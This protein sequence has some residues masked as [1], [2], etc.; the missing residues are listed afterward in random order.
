VEQVIGAAMC[1]RRAEYQQFG[2]MDEQFFMYFEEV[3]LCKRII[4][5]G[6]QVWFR[7]EAVV[8]HLGG[9]SA[10]ASDVRARMIVAFRDSRRQYFEKHFGNL[11]GELINAINRLEGLQK[12]VVLN[13]YVRIRPSSV[14]RE[15]AYGFWL[16]AT[17]PSPHKEPM[18]GWEHS[19]L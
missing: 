18:R 2:G 11:Q 5:G 1:M 3:D 14:R 9:R 8:Q 15:R 4:D 6:R 7:P 17:Q 10:E 19:Q 16:A 13:I 12:A